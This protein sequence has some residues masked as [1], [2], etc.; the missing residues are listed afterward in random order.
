[1]DTHDKP[2]EAQR[3][4]GLSVLLK[5]TKKNNRGIKIHTNG[6]TFKSNVSL[7]ELRHAVEKTIKTHNIKLIPK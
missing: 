4:F 7:N 5:L 1:M 6:D 3:S 2:F